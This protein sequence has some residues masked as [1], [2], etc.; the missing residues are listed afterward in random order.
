MGPICYCD[1]SGRTALVRWSVFQSSNCASSAIGLERVGI[2]FSYICLSDPSAWVIDI[3]IDHES[4]WGR[5]FRA[6]GKRSESQRLHWRRCVRILPSRR[7]KQLSAHR[8][9]SDVSASQ[10]KFDGR[11][12]HSRSQYSPNLRSE[13]ALHDGRRKRQLLRDRNFLA[14]AR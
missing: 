3:C 6:K 5:R 4:R 13:F 2:C 9:P 14:A 8:A 1:W 7:R 10:Q 11:Q 12:I